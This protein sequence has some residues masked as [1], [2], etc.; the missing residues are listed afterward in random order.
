MWY[1]ILADV[2]QPLQRAIS[3]S[4]IRIGYKLEICGAKVNF[5]F[6]FENNNKCKYFNV[7]LNK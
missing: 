1:K 4:K 6:I 3:K 5:K 2:D 7:N